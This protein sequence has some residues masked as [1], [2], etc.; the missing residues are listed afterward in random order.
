[1]SDVSRFR[2]SATVCYGK[3]NRSWPTRVKPLNDA[4]RG[5]TMK[6]IVSMLLVSLLASACMGA[7]SGR[8]PHEDSLG[9]MPTDAGP[10]L[11]HDGTPPPC[12]LRD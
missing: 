12:P 11:C 5:G 4:N 8:V 2:V 3:A 9:A 7:G 1:M 10:M 6:G